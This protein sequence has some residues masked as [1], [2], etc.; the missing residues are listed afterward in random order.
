MFSCN[1]KDT[2]NTIETAKEQKISKKQS[3]STIDSLIVC[4][5]LKEKLLYAF[6]RVDSFPGWEHPIVYIVS[7]RMH[8][9]YISIGKS[10]AVHGGNKKDY[11]CV[12]YFFY[13][14]KLIQIFDFL[15]NKENA[16]YYNANWLNYYN[17]TILS[18]YGFKNGHKVDIIFDLNLT[19]PLLS[20]T[21]EKIDSG[22]IVVSE[23][24]GK[25]EYDFK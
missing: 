16:N 14:N 18:P 6:D 4:K 12:G 20:L 17:D 2:P 11:G 5:Q 21:L 15:N 19:I 25:G 10:I 7:F 3:V 23:N 9:I 24:L 13:G 22:L 8:D 1:Q